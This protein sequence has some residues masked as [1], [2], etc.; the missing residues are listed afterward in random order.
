MGASFSFTRR[1]KACH[2]ARVISRRRYWSSLGLVALVSGGLGWFVPQV[3][4]AFTP[5]RQKMLTQF[6]SAN[7]GG[8][9]DFA[10]FGVIEDD[11]ALRVSVLNPTGLRTVLPAEYDEL[12]QGA[13]YDPD[14]LGAWHILLQAT[15]PH[16]DDPG[17]TDY[18][19][20]RWPVTVEFGATRPGTVEAHLKR[21]SFPAAVW[22]TPG[23][24]AQ[25][26]L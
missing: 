7:L 22:R 15:P 5:T 26:R 25:C 11:R 2:A 24:P 21:F 10:A 16:G 17:Y 20:W 3:V 14:C 19:E 18:R 6:L 8:H 13:R 1:A 4:D 9:P 23:P 12:T